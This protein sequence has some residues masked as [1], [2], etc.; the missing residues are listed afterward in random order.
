[1]E[2]DKIIRGLKF[3]Y[4]DNGEGPRTI[5]LMHGWGCNHTT[6]AT[7]ERTALECGLR[8]VNVDFPGF[9]G[10]AE[11][12]AVWGVEEYTR[13]IEQLIDELGIKNPILLGH[14][15][16]GRVGILYASRHPEVEKLIL[17]DAAGVK[18]KRPLKYYW[19]VYSFKALKYIM[20]LSMGKKEAEHRLDHRRSKA[21]SAD[22]AKASPMMR[23]ILSKVVN[24][25]LQLEMPKIKA[26]TLLIWG[27]NDTATPMRDAEIMEKLI[28]NAGLVAF[29]GAGHY[30][31]LDNMQGFQAVLKNF[32]N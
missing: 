4:T 13:G 11:P 10:S 7:I 14:S 16:G 2:N 17:V 22:Y 28:P 6:L 15:F 18:P 20:Y 24:E 3:H 31:F 29:D 8:V 26:P 25:D 19:K 9:G 21:G 27:K 30:S 5:V 12:D 32:L 23:R 1:M